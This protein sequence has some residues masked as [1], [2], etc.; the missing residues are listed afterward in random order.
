[1]NAVLGWDDLELLERIRAAGTLGGAARAL[2]VDQTTASRRLSAL[3][4]RAGAKLFARL[5]GKLVATAPLAS[6]ADRLRA[7]SELAAASAAILKDETIDMRAN[8]RVTSVGFLLVH[9]LAPALGAFQSAHPGVSLEFIADDRP[10]SF[11]HREMDVALRLG[12]KAEDSTRIKRLGEVGFRLCRPAALAGKDAA[13]LPVVRY[14]DDL[15]DLPEM[16]ALAR[17]RPQAQV[18][19][20]S[21]R[22]DI[23]I[24]AALALGAEIMLPERVAERDPRFA[25]LAETEATASRPAFLMTHPDRATTPSVVAVASWMAATLSPFLRRG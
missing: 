9:A 15:L 16:R 19:F 14:G 3:E 4:R 5:D 24:E 21:S 12:P 10:L 18:A 11:E 8:V 23:L 13:E 17:A 22:L 25:P 1:M 2:G 6:I 20:K 7:M